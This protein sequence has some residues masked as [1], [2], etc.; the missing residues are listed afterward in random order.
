MV[1]FTHHSWFPPDCVSLL[2]QCEPCTEAMCQLSCGN[3]G[4]CL[5]CMVLL[6]PRCEV[7]SFGWKLAER[8]LNWNRLKTQTWTIT[9]VWLTYSNSISPA[10][11]LCVWTLELLAH[12]PWFV[13]H[14]CTWAATHRLCFLRNWLWWAWC[15]ACSSYALRD[16]FFWM[17]PKGLTGLVIP[18]VLI[19]WWC[20]SMSECAD[21]VHS[22]F[23][24]SWLAI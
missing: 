17:L 15:A 11:R 3:L 12:K 20:E 8:S 9:E 5:P 21:W 1:A 14:T 22:N 4:S 23:Q 13:H 6:C 10:H 24:G 2:T 19:I 16:P 7:M 18:N